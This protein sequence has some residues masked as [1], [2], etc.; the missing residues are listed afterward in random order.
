MHKKFTA[1]K[2]SLVILTLVIMASVLDAQYYDFTTTTGSYSDL[3]G[4]TSLNN[5]Q[6]WTPLVYKYEVPLGFDFAFFNM[7][8]NKIYIADLVNFDL[9]GHFYIN[10]F[11]VTYIWRP[12]ADISYLI[13][14]S[15]GNRIAKVQWKNVGFYFENLNLG[16]TNDYVNIQLWLYE[17]THKIE[18]RIGT[19]SVLNP[20]ASYGGLGGPFI[21]IW[22]IVS[23]NPT[24][25]QSVVL[26]GAPS[27]PTAVVNTSDFGLILNGTPPNGTIYNFASLT[28]GAKEMLAEENEVFYVFP[29][30]ALDV[31]YLSPGRYNKSLTSIKLRD[32]LGKTVTNYIIDGQGDNL[33]RI[34]IADL[35]HGI[36]FIEIRAENQTFH[37]KILKF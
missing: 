31:L 9:N 36:Y 12:G 14:G 13:D 27:S 5:G 37:K 10:A 20:D 30:P 21:G 18:I 16:T 34:N 2:K 11:N 35:P 6:P 22:H 29:Q 19:S 3:V 17:T 24:V 1:M 8:F 33:Y 25:C 26:T 7:N 15:M 28:S 4:A 32:F 23:F